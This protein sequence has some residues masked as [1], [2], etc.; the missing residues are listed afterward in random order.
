MKYEVPDTVVGVAPLVRW[1][2]GHPNRR[3]VL[4]L[5][6][7][8]WSPKKRP[9][10]AEANA[11]FIKMVLAENYGDPA[12]ADLGLTTKLLDACS[13]FAHYVTWG[14]DGDCHPPTPADDFL[15][16][17]G[18]E[19]G[20][21]VVDCSNAGLFRP[22]WTAGTSRDDPGGFHLEDQIP[23]AE[24]VRDA[25]DLFQHPRTVKTCPQ[26]GFPFIAARSALVC[27][28]SCKAAKARG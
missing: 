2:C 20:A 22:H 12:E 23:S 6:L 25:L 21:L 7:A 1:A 16:D 26:C 14:E 3:R 10:N 9:E 11:Q 13:T 28:P 15:D 8:E 17:A 19:L 24:I 4:F 27:S 18:A 5:T